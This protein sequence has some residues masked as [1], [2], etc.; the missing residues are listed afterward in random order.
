MKD[1]KE[2]FLEATIER[3]YSYFIE[4]QVNNFKFKKNL[5]TASVPNKESHNVVIETTKNGHFEKMVCDC[6]CLSNE[7]CPHLV[8]V[9]FE[10][11]KYLQNNSINNIT[12]LVSS[13]YESQIRHFL[14]VILKENKQLAQLFQRYIFSD[15]Q[16]DLKKYIDKDGN[17]LIPSPVDNDSSN[18]LNQTKKRTHFL[19]VKQM[20][21][22]NYSKQKIRQH[23][24]GDWESPTVRT[25]YVNY[26][27]E[28]KLYEE[29]E[30]VL[31]ESITLDSNLPHLILLH[32]YSLK[33]LYHKLGRKEEYIHQ[34][35]R[36]LI[37]NETVD[38][39]LIHQ[40]KKN[41]AP[42]EWE[43]IQEQLFKDLSNHAGVSL[44]YLQEKRYDLLL[45]YVLE[46]PGLTEAN[47]YFDLLKE[48]TPEALLQ[49][50]EYELRKMA[51]TTTSR[52]H[53]QKIALYIEKMA[54][55][56]N[57]MIS[58]HLLIKE[59][60]EKYTRRKSLIQI[61]EQLEKRI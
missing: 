21:L 28:K 61:L 35:K 58:V 31:K 45:D 17:V 50:Y 34:M 3:G 1:W 26:L 8:A 27:L 60:K 44:L 41:C 10:Y 7:E 23:I 4:K 51:C 48:Q 11:N 53:Y 46:T 33:N 6:S 36:L 9:L 5:V 59:L 13:A 37:E 30:E 25:Q 32:R 20:R 49:K 52:P 55:L 38:M 57:S 16:L 29:A 12:Y 47:R 2:Y 43:N 24:E 18:K 14:K 15:E 42:M 56:P 40:L 54:T 22:L 19:T 39:A